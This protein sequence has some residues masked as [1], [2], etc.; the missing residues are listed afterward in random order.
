MK[1]VTPIKLLNGNRRLLLNSNSMPI[2]AFTQFVEH[3]KVKLGLG[4]GTIVLYSDNVAKFI[5]YLIEAG[6]FLCDNA[7]TQDAL[8]TAVEAYPDFLVNG[9]SSTEPYIVTIA[10]RMEFNGIKSDGTHIAAVNHFLT[11]AVRLAKDMK[12]LAEIETGIKL[13]SPAFVFTALE[14]EVKMSHH[15]IKRIKENSILGANLRVIKSIKK[16]KLKSVRKSSRTSIIDPNSGVSLLEQMEEYEEGRKRAFPF[17]RFQ[18]LL[19]KEP[20]PRNRTLWSLLGG[21]GLRQSEGVVTYIPLVMPEMQEVY[22]VDPND[23]R[24]SSKYENPKRWKGRE[25]AKVYLIPTIR[26]IFFDSYREWMK[27]RP[28]SEEDFVFLKL[29]DVGYGQPLHLAT[30]WALNKA[31]K[32]AQRRIGMTRIYSL[33]SLRHLYG[34]FMIN[35]FPTPW[36]N[37]PG[38]DLNTVQT[39]MGHASITSTQ[40]YAIKDKN[41]LEAKLEAADRMLMG[42]TH[43]SLPEMIIKNL[44]KQADEFE[45]LYLNINKQTL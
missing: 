7:P 37:E 15:E 32:V 21:G 44:R 16:N 22:I 33:H 38:L 6:V 45:R 14:G 26:Q 4:A 19:E 31:F 36:K 30:Y 20:C 12:L 43:L 23:Y 25:T 11:F 18:E 40:G 41:V 3:M 35:F 13:D 28:E 9:V 10:E 5:D 42:E 17:D 34:V 29:D 27:I 8:D 2:D 1:N 24:G 39:L